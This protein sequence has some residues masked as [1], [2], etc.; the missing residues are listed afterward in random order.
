MN[1]NRI[2]EQ[3]HRRHALQRFGPV[4][5]IALGVVRFAREHRRNELRQQ[6]RVHLPV[7]IQLDDDVRTGRHR[8]PVTGHHR[9]ADATIG[10]MEDDLQAGIVALLLQQASRPL[11]AR[12]VHRHDQAHFGS[13]PADQVDDMGRD[14]VAGDHH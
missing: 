4:E 2:A 8:V 9:P 14:L 7:A 11:R 10:L 1:D 5:A 12:I 3:A 13:D 6:C